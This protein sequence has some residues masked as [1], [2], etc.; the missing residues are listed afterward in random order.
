MTH[1][2]RFVNC[3]SADFEEMS[4]NILV[5][6]A[7]SS[8]L[9]F[10]LYKMERL[11]DA[12]QREDKLASGKL[13]RIGTPEARLQVSIGGRPTEERPVDAQT[14]D[15][16]AEQVISLLKGP[17]EANIRPPTP[18]PRSPTIDAV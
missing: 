18:D 1:P 5:L 13:E 11:Q 4:V 2:R 9:K 6:N 12:E 7:G 15:H 16:A 17:G 3:A 8:S 14:M 10:S